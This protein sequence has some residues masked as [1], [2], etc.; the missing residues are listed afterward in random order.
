MDLQNHTPFRAQLFRTAIDDDRIAASLVTK[1][2]YDLR[3]TALEP[4]EEQPWLISAEPWESEYGVIDTDQL[5]YRGGVDLFLFGH[6]RPE[7]RDT[8]SLT[9]AV[10]VGTEWKREVAVF[11]VRVWRKGVSGL[12]ATSPL[13]IEA[14]PLTMAFAFGGKDRWDGLEV[15]YPLNPDGIGCYLWQDS[16]EGKPL[17]NLEETDQLISSWEDKPLPAGVA[18]C[19]PMSGIRLARLAGPALKAHAAGKADPMSE[20]PALQFDATFFNAAHP[21]MIVP[22]V[23][24]GTRIALS[25][26]TGGAPLLVDVPGTLPRARVRFDDEVDERPLAIDQIGIE[27]DKKRVF[28]SY[29]FPFR[30][31]VVPEQMREAHLFL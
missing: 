18:P 19:P 1:V 12:H 27:A 7:R 21:R 10:R 2:T 8:K 6:A 5:F 9:V 16:A 15:P 13:P 3:G 11:G 24:P 4:S 23:A 31:V 30:Y 22:S 28:I 29:R 20:G 14:I 17:P 25:G 26:V